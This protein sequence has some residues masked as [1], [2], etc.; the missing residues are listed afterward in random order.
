MGVLVVE[1]ATRIFGSMMSMGYYGI[2]ILI[3]GLWVEINDCNRV[4]QKINKIIEMRPAFLKKQSIMSPNHFMHEPISSHYAMKDLQQTINP[5]NHL[6]HRNLCKCNLCGQNGNFLNHNDDLNHL[7]SNTLSGKKLFKK[8]LEGLTTSG[9]KTLKIFI[10]DLFFVEGDTL[11]IY[12]TSKDSRMSK[13]SGATPIK[14]MYPTM[15]RMRKEYKSQHSGI[16]VL[17]GSCP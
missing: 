16:H 12:Q 5:D 7:E 1:E 15:L 17:D 14:H 2:K 9:A 11:E 10:P 13:L 3:C 6:P 8:L 4:Q